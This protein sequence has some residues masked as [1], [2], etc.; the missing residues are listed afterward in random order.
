MAN[1]SAGLSELARFN[2]LARQE[3]EKREK[4]KDDD[5]RKRIATDKRDLQYEEEKHEKYIQKYVLPLL[6]PYSPSRKEAARKV[7]REVRD[8][9]DRKWIME[10][11]MHGSE[12]I[13]KKKRKDFQ[14]AGFLERWGDKLMEIP[15]AFL[16]GSNLMAE[17]AKGL[18]RV[19]GGALG[20]EGDRDKKELR[21]R[22]FLEEAYEYG[23]PGKTKEDNAAFKALTGGAKIAPQ[24]LTGKAAFS[25]AG[26]AGLASQ[27]G[28]S[29]F[30]PQRSRLMSEGVDEAAANTIA[31]LTSAFGGIVE[32]AVP[33]PGVG[34]SGL[35]R[36]GGEAVGELAKKLGLGAAGRKIAKTAG[37]VGAEYLGEVG[38]EFVQAGGE[39]L[40]SLVGAQHEDKLS[41]RSLSEIPQEALG[42]ARE[43]VLPLA[44]ISLLGGGGRIA[45][46][47]QQART[48]AAVERFAKENKAP[49]R[50]EWK[51][52]GLPMEPGTQQVPPTKVRLGYVKKL[53]DAYGALD[54]LSDEQK[55]SEQEIAVP[56]AP[57]EM[58][59]AVA[60]T[61]D[62][63]TAPVEQDPAG[64][65]RVEPESGDLKARLLE[66]RE[67]IGEPAEP[68]QETRDLRAQLLEA[69]NR[70]SEPA[71]PAPVEEGGD[72]VSD[73]EAAEL[74]ELSGQVADEATIRQNIA[75]LI[76]GESGA[77]P[78]GTVIDDTVAGLPPEA[79]REAVKSP[80]PENE[81]R[82]AK[83]NV[84]A[85]RE[86]FWK[87]LS[88]RVAELGRTFVRADVH[89]PNFGDKW[90]VAN[91][92]MRLKRA[93][94][95]SAFNRALGNVAKV[96]RTPGQELGP[97]QS[98]L[99]ERYLVT[100]NQ[101]RSLYMETPEPRR[102]GVKSIEA[103][104]A[105]MEQ[106]RVLVSETP[107]V[108]AAL[109]RRGEITAALAQELHAAG[110][111]NE[112]ALDDVESY[113][114]Q[115]VL[116]Y[117]NA[118]RRG[119]A[120]KGFMKERVTGPEALDEEFDYNTSYLGP[121]VQ[122]MTHAY[123][124][125]LKNEYD[126][127]IEEKY[128]RYEEF[129]A[130]ALEEGKSIG[131]I[132]RGEGYEVTRARKLYGSKVSSIS[133]IVMDQYT[134]AMYQNEGLSEEE[135]DINEGP[136]SARMIALPKEIMAQLD[137]DALAN[138]RGIKEITGD[139]HKDA[140]RS[141]K[142]WTLTNPMRIIG[143]NA[144]NFLGD[145]DPI[146][147]A[148][149][150]AILEIAQ[151]LKDIKSLSD[152]AKEQRPE[153]L[154]SMKYGVMGS[155]VTK[156][157]IGSVGELPIFSGLRKGLGKYASKNPFMA[158]IRVARAGTE[159]RENLLRHATFLN[160]LKKVKSGDLKH[161]GASRA[162][163]VKIIQRHFGDE[164]A[165]AHLARNLLGDY[166][167]L[168]M[169]GQLWRD[170]LLPF[171]SYTEV[172]MKRYPLILKNS[173]HSGKGR[174]ATGA[175]LSKIATVRIAQMYGMTWLWN[176]MMYPL[177][178]GEDDE[179]KLGDYDRN[180][181]YILT[182]HNSDGTVRVF[183]SVGSLSELLEWV[184][185]N[186]ALSLIPQAMNGQID[187]SDVGKE[188]ATAPLEKMISLLHPGIKAA[189]ELLSGKS[190]FPDPFNQRPQEPDM[191]VANIFGLRDEV[192]AIKGAVGGTGERARNNYWQK[193]L[194][195]G[196]VD[197]RAA[198]LGEMYGLRE[199][200]FKQKGISIPSSGVI[201]EYKIA[202]DAAIRDDKG[203]FLDWKE[204][205]IERHGVAKASEKFWRHQESI[206][207]ISDSMNADDRWEFEYRYLN[208]GQR[209]RF[210]VAREFSGELRDRM[211]FWWM[212]PEAKGL[213]GK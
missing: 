202:R 81:R 119:S 136:D 1:G 30:A 34:K 23:E 145:I 31:G 59:E 24:L 75:D 151:S 118:M 6:N 132:A 58:M 107:K 35:G 92:W 120:G 196:V 142:A 94:Q 200:F 209:A 93:A 186:E 18:G 147:A 66:A 11:V 65:V 124:A 80:D 53:A 143:Y 133:G 84:P 192:K 114:H 164:A 167:N 131:N 70:L 108:Q 90:V 46:N 48:R 72:E 14:D 117:R 206:D 116:L 99:L 77:L 127:V 150:G 78:I 15:E 61:P 158:Y 121:E 125:L 98:L 100:S 185:V 156:G 154:A 10:K 105:Y 68:T 175:V 62:Q 203:A 12:L 73:S 128:D 187:W 104:E 36:A 33:I 25:I 139:I 103:A 76:A 40:G 5:V 213:G 197:P 37:S 19:L 57:A 28:A 193:F 60:E 162:S 160:Y 13:G 8:S 87:R 194:G 122:W 199:S 170:H 22:G 134:Q 47:V 141:W 9:Q 7:S 129:S 49:S 157:E 102:H 130:K 41:G 211:T 26:K 191:A 173:F 71:P 43:S 51:E 97:D 27:A 140:M 50:K 110:L 109:K 16:E 161:Y 2:W 113:V 180:T 29:M 39:A 67:R 177:I 91:T 111:L 165:A 21:Y 178:F 163:A 101:L 159:A 42:A 183:R 172:N 181:M 174:T 123:E 204:N 83:A 106:L 135:I 205:F 82:L 208:T 115:E 32:T 168:S 155:G 189:Y 188:V 171:W 153:T 195:Q 17:S 148:N 126:H 96:L 179:E 85:V 137:E 190:L 69:R 184:G 146:L 54:E 166:G 144:R 64:R 79:G 149:P 44:P 52:L 74:K 176:N 89:I 63:P 169:M 95:P 210:R 198:A 88:G 20:G 86:K 38:E 138:K 207:P 152:P 55:P 3:D 4:R 201:S 56:T 182:G 45:G 212:N 112:S